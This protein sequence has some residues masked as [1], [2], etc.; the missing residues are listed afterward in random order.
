M[1]LRA[2]REKK[3]VSFSCEVCNDTVLK[4]KLDAHRQRCPG[5]YFTCIDCSVTFSGTEYR[6]HTSCISEAE[7]YEK[8]LYRG[9]GKEKA[10]V[11]KKDVKEKE[12]GTADK[13][14][15][16]VEKKKSEKTEKTKTD[17]K[18]E[19]SKIDK[20]SERSEKS[21]TDKKSSASPSPLDA[22][23]KPVSLYKLAKKLDKKQKKALL[24][25]IEVARNNG[26]LRVSVKY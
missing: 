3:M 15:V 17:K 19:K 20:K 5:A 18:S 25:S 7:K 21:K 6:S 26:E 9:K 23:S 14:E 22:V 8:G 24:E 13:K 12:V 2:H 16:K 1:R 11:A 10:G 4:K